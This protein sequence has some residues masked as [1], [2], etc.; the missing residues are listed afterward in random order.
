M[1]ITLAIGGPGQV[2]EVKRQ[3]LLQILYSFLF[4]RT[5]TSQPKIGTPRDENAVFLGDHI[6]RVTLAFDSFHGNKSFLRLSKKKEPLQ[7]QIIAYKSGQ[8]LARVGKAVH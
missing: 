5:L 1:P 7:A 6:I 3:R 2:L 4:R 8:V